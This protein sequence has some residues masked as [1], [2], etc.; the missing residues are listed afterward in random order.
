MKM[1]TQE[2]KIKDLE[3]QM[4][5]FKKIADLQQQ[6]RELRKMVED[7]KHLVLEQAI[8]EVEENYSIDREKLISKCRK[9]E[10]VLPRHVLMYKLYSVGFKLAEI[11]DIL[12]NRDHTSVIH[13]VRKIGNQKDLYDDI[14]L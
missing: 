4:K 9:R 5:D 12:G 14:K 11:G 6:I 13:A 8:K 10:Y 3:R 7:S 2:Q 1:K